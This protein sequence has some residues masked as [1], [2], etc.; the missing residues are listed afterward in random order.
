MSPTPPGTPG[1]SSEVSCN[2]DDWGAQCHAA[3]TQLQ[4]IAE[5]SEERR[6]TSEQELRNMVEQVASI[7]SD[8]RFH[9]TSRSNPAAPGLLR[10]AL[11]LLDLKDLK[12]V[13]VLFKLARCALIMLAMDVAVS[14][15]SATGVE[16]AYL[17]IAKLLL[18]YSKN[19]GY[20]TE[21][22]EA[23]LLVPL[24][25]LLQSDKVE[26]KSNELRVFIVGVLK[27]VVFVDEGNQQLLVQKG[28]VPVLFNLMSN[29]N[30][31][32]G[33]KKEEPLLIQITAT[34][35]SLA[36]HGYTQFITDDRPHTLTKVMELY[37]NNVELLT[38]VSRTLAK[39][40]VHGSACEAYTK[41]GDASHL[42]RITRTLSANA[43]CAPL[44]LRLSFTLGNLTARNDRTR[45]GFAFDC[46]GNALAPTLLSKY[47]QKDRQL[48]RLPMNGNSSA[49]TTTAAAKQEVEEVLV[50]LVRL[51]ANIAIERKAGET[52]ASCSAAVD[53]LLDMLG[54]KRIGD[55]EELVLNVVAAI[56][57]LL[58]YDVPSSLL[59]LED[60]KT[61]L[62][63][64]FR[65]LL[66]ESYNVEAL[67]ETARALGNLSRHEDARRCMA[68]IRL[69]EIL[70][71][72]LDHDDRN[73]VFYVCGALVNLASDPECTPRLT[74]ACPVVGK[75]GKLLCDA[76]PDD[77]ALQLVAVKVLTNLS[78]DPA[79]TT[80]SNAASE[81]VREALQQI[82][83]E[84]SQEVEQLEP[85]EEMRQL[86]DLSQQLLARLA[87][88]APAN[89]G[90]EWTCPVPGCLRRFADEAKLA[91][92][93]ERR[94]A[95]LR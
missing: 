13:K 8:A 80:W 24:L 90:G 75:L 7:V 69:D 54:S 84:S 12:D 94:H 62:C 59:F 89:T 33:S 28:A 72:L 10:V 91:A 53:P 29:A 21:F 61:L 9:D 93:M 71:I 86:L 60:N 20:D 11:G 87:P 58:Y 44:V 57:N 22:L 64:L 47:W 45:I 27:N 85:D 32:G 18:K 43:D 25:E 23:D 76:P 1:R 38:N 92:H 56:T 81:D 95:E 77:T 16:N 78:R 4:A 73:L 17:N 6:R 35:R 46:E 37:P 2:G 70:T 79:G 52:L 55:S 66:L 51:I 30:L 31:V 19:Q 50:K 15:V 5:S 49:E 14:G 39:L 88:A 26:C 83:A 74:S 82:L 68:E 63:R 36:G 65:P 40:T 48:A 34:L 3:L 42:R 67:V 41:S